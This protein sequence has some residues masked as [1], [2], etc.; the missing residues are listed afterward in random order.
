M[1][2]TIRSGLTLLTF[3]S[4]AGF[5]SRM[6]AVSPPPDDG[7]PGGNTAEGYLALGGLTTGTYNSA[8]GIY[9][10]LSLTTG[11]LNTANG[12]GTLLVN[13]ADENT[14]TGAA[15]LLSNSTGAGNT[16]NGAFA[17][18]SNTIGEENTATGAFALFYN[19][20][21]YFNTATAA[22]ALFSNTT[23]AYNTAIGNGAL[24]SNTTGGYNTA[25]GVSALESNA[26]GGANTATGEG[27]LFANTVGDFNTANGF[28]A[29]SNNTTG[30]F[31]TAIGDE[32]LDRN[33]GGGANTATGAGALSFNETGSNNTAI[34]FG[35][36]SSSQA[37]NNNTGVGVQAGIGVTTASYV[38]CIGAGGANVN[39][40]C[41]I[42]NIW[43][44][45]DG[46][47]AVYV[48]SEGKL[49]AQVS[50]R[51][52]KDEVKPMEW[53]SEVIYSL[54][55]VTFRYKPEI[56]PTRPPGFGLIAE[57]VEEISFDLVTRGGDGQANSVRYDAVNAML[58]NEFLKEHRKVEQQE[59]AIAQ[60]ERD[61]QMVSTQQQKEIQLLSAQLK[62][63]ASQIRKVRD[64]VEMNDA[65][66]RAVANNE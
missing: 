40:S 11:S 58:L 3:L 7:Y 53:A 10:L 4:L 34:G 47:Q 64:Q 1:K 25:T 61:F 22:E 14:A 49:G 39:N 66:T 28:D 24:F 48:N 52:F 23:G 26:E 57:E 2:I 19:T 46:T 51:R 27:A 41:Y 20:E 12:A 35:A 31:N 56:E 55:P 9:S 36:L 32:A 6:Q 43:N 21:G 37:G 38:I 63:Q 8:V 60:L 30:G 13:T 33:T 17:L 42:G 65:A 54:R 50:S 29:L 62:E 15:A 18:F 5:G 59:A 44:Q 45:S 16:A